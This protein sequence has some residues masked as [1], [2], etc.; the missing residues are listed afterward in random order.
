[1]IRKRL[2]GFAFASADL[3]LELDGEGATVFGMGSGPAAGLSAESFCGAALSSRIDPISIDKL[4]DVLKSLRPGAR[5]APVELL[6]LAGEGRMRRATARFFLLPDLAPNISCSITWEGP[7][8][9]LHDPEAAPAL[10]PEAFLRRA[11]EVMAPPAQPRDLAVAFV[12]VE[13]LAAAQAMGEA[14]ERLNARV[15]AALQAASVGGATAGKLGPE[16]FALVRD[17]DDDVDIAGEMNEIGRSEGFEL[18]ARAAESDLTAGGESLSALRALRVAV[19]GCLKEGGAA[20]ELSFTA[21]L[22]RTLNDAHAFQAM[23]RDRRFD[24]H[25]QP[26]VDLKT[27]AVHHFEALARF[28]GSA[29]PANAI[30]MAEEMALIDSFDVAVA[31]KA[32]SRLRQQG[33]GLLKFAVNVSGA[34][35]ADDRYVQALLRMTSGRPEERRRLIVEVTE[36]AALS[37]VEA[38]NR[39]LGALRAAGIKVCIDDFGAGAASYDYLRRLSVDTVKIDGSFVQGLEADPKARTLI[40]HLVELCRSLKVETIAEMIETQG[41]A[42]ILR[43][44][45]VDQGQGWLFGKAEAE[46][47]THLAANE[48][49]ARRMGA[50]A[51]WG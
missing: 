46:P 50:V 7:A 35:L 21:A 33:A 30:R 51:S 6:F 14:G 40:G 3:L 26:I 17:R 8:F 29:S 37:D 25:Y 31:E 13:G 9:A 23:V 18:T 27:G 12:D 44:I 47:R 45:G 2:L 19:E 28:K 49:V 43:E 5:T 15:E 39:R 4:D 48:P 34:S 24:L 20:P 36:S 22:S 1:M 32:L 11:R 10:T 41:A 42:D 16:R 38:A